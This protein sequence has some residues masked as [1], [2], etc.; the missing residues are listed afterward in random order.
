M[1]IKVKFLKDNENTGHKKG[2]VDDVNEARAS[3]W[4]DQGIAERVDADSTFATPEDKDLIEEG[5]EK[6][7]RR[8]PKGTKRKKRTLMR[9][10]K[11]ND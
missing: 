6:T 2:D 5:K 7:E 8:K 4:I 10:P 9:G 1:A 11:E 3:S